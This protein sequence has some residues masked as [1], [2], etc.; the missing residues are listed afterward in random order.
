MSTRPDFWDV[1]TTIA[2]GQRGL[3]AC[4]QIL[5]AGASRAALDS[6][7]R[8]GRLRPM[9]RAVFLVPG[10]PVDSE[11]ALLAQVLAAGDEAALSHESGAWLW[12]L[13]DSAPP[14]HEISV[15]RG[16]R[17]RT[18]SL[19]VH[20]ST[21][22]DLVVPGSIRGLPVTDVGRTILDCAGRPGVDLDLLIDAARREHQISRTLLP[23]IVA[24]HARSG[25][26]GIEAL[27]SVLELDEFP[28]SDFE[29]LV[30][31]W[32][33]ARGIDGWALHHQIVIDGFGPV[34]LDLAWPD[35][36][37]ALE[38]EGLL[39]RNQRVVHD[40]DTERQNWI[41]I[42]GWDVLRLT[43]RRWIRHSEAVLTEIRRKIA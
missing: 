18:P 41:S 16:R 20:Q 12:Q 40:D 6:S 37:V 5:A 31:R 3:V 29:R 30:C 32:L 21:D 8:S 10:A 25:R 26:R 22:L 24:Q 35:R 15:P 23:W 9:A 36:R 11:V 33:I 4:R 42:A 1:V 14:V 39:H 19:I 38:L 17:P 28:D 34:E 43:Y 7:V 13:V 2:E 27:R